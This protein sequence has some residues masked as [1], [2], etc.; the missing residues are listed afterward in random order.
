MLQLKSNK[1]FYKTVYKKIAATIHWK[2]IQ[3]LLIL[4]TTTAALF[5]NCATYSG[6]TAAEMDRLVAI[7]PNIPA[8]F[9]PIGL[10]ANGK[11][12]QGASRSDHGFFQE[13]I[14]I[15][16]SS[17]KNVFQVEQSTILLKPG[18][19]Q[20]QEIIQKGTA[21]ISGNHLNVHF[22]YQKWR[23]RSSATPETL[24]STNYNEWIIP[25]I[26]RET[27]FKYN[28]A[29]GKLRLIV[30][31]DR[32]NLGRSTE[33]VDDPA[34]PE[35]LK[36]GRYDFSMDK[37]I[38]TYSSVKSAK[39]KTSKRRVVFRGSVFSVNNAGKQITIYSSKMNNLKPGNTVDVINMK[40]KATV[41]KARI[42]SINFTNA[43]AKLI[44]GNIRQINRGN[45]IIRFR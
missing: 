20:Q 3:T 37:S 43:R 12:G 9:S 8:T 21:K 29:T 36:Q 24:F 28:R 32:I 25:A 2:K 1:L 34:N 40:T 44:S 26:D 7:D 30:Y 42:T 15:Q 14:N 13:S 18:N 11:D 5:S 19:T 38:I 27:L 16:P 41:G 4:A 6:Y 45:A 35:M 17:T 31:Y 39:E 10:W 22:T 33:W 23:S